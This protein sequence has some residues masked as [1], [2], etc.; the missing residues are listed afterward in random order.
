MATALHLACLVS[1]PYKEPALLVL[2]VADNA[3]LAKSALV[4]FQD[5]SSSNIDVFKLTS[6]TTA[7][8]SDQASVSDCVIRAGTSSR[9]T[10]SLEDARMDLYPISTE[11][12][13]GNGFI[14][15]LVLPTTNKASVSLP[16][17]LGSGKLISISVALALPTAIDA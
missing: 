9:V 13:T 7:S 11:V 5:T 16:V 2:R 17:A 6:A 10:A 12:V 1:T 3:R 15:V 4:V 14:S 8:T